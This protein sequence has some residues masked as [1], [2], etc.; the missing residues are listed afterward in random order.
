MSSY[1]IFKR[2]KF[3]ETST[4]FLIVSFFSDSQTQFIHFKEFLYSYG[5]QIK[6][7]KS[8][9]IYACLNNYTSKSFLSSIKTV[10]TGPLFLIKALNNNSK[11]LNILLNLDKKKFLEHKMFALL[12]YDKGK[13]HNFENIS[14]L[15]KNVYLNFIKTFYSFYINLF[16]LLKF[17]DIFLINILILYLNNDK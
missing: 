3:L 14:I 16:T 5:L 9:S 7:I 6:V 13:I 17:Y 12:C 1:R 10:S 15:N 11:F 8:K 2:N 4:S